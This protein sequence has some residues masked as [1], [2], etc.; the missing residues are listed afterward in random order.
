[1]AQP[2]HLGL[3]IRNISAELLNVVA[4][5]EVLALHAD[6]LGKMGA[7]VTMSD[8]RLN[9]TQVWSRELSDGSRMIGLLNLGGGANASNADTCTWETRT[10]GYF[11]SGP[12][13][14]FACY[15]DATVPEMKA[16]CCAAGLK[17]CVGFNTPSATHTGGCAKRDSAGGWLNASGEDDFI[18]TKGHDDPVPPPPRRICVAWGD[19][20]LN[21]QETLFVRDLWQ[22]KS[23]GLFA[24]E[25]CMVVNGHDTALLHV[26]SKSCR[27]T[28][29]LKSDD[30]TLDTRARL[31]SG[32]ELP[33][34]SFR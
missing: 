5:K 2:L 9:G 17:E 28:A 11:Q 24:E 10:G 25:F 22:H 13:G 20:G 4:N 34:S 30:I 15:K 14:N 6:P 19:V 12:R 18:I 27:P 3:D 23:L 7:R 31:S 1:M 26:D 33:S 21:P 8:G 32:H 29:R 16:A